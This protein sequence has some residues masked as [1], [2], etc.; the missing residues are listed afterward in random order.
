MAV[1]VVLVTALTVMGSPNSPLHP[2]HQ[3]IFRPDTPTAAENVRLKLAS[4]RA[5]LDQAS[6]GNAS[7]TPADLAQARRLLAEARDQLA[8]VSDPDTRSELENE[9]ANLQQRANQLGDDPDQNQPPGATPSARNDQRQD[10]QPGGGHQQGP[11]EP[12][13]P[14]PTATSTSQPT[15][16]STGGEQSH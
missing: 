8:Q 14:S 1:A 10:Q 11:N 9:L 12:A 15:D 2:L 16:G 4:A 13:D 7:P 6:G 3:L 5:T